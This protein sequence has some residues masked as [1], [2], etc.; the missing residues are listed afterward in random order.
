MKSFIKMIV[1]PLALLI[2][3]PTIGMQSMS[4]SG[5]AL[6]KSASDHPVYAAGLFGASALGIGAAILHRQGKLGSTVK[7]VKDAAQT[8]HAKQLHAYAAGFAFPLVT[9]SATVFAASRVSGISDSYR[10]YALLAAIP[11]WYFS[12]TKGMNWYARVMALDAGQEP[13]PAHA[14]DGKN[15][16]RMGDAAFLSTVLSV[17]GTFLTAYQ[18]ISKQ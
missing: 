1:A 2:S 15:R 3:L 11:A 17:G 13:V 18:Q 8:R 16:K 10:N 5:S 14:R 6:I 7:A 12:T 9:G 4:N